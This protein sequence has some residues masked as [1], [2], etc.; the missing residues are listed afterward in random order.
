MIK[1][2]KLKV[3][4][5]ARKD[6][7]IGKVLAHVGHVCCKIM[8]D[9]SHFVNIE[10]WFY[11]NYQTKIILQIDNEELR[12]WLE[13]DDS[14]YRIRDMHT[15]EIYCIATPPLTDVEAKE[16]GLKKLRLFG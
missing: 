7:P 14:F 15:D 3:Y 6:A 4:I 11:T 12:S 1:I 9:M 10:N 8:T 5:L 16:L 13:K 2:E